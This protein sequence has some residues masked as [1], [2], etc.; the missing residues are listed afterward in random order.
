MQNYPSLKEQID[1]ALQTIRSRT[2]SEPTIGVILGTGLSSLTDNI[3]INLEIPYEEIPNFP[4]STVESHAG[5]LIFG[6]IAG[7]DIVAMQGRFHFYEGYSM[8]QITFP[9]RVMKWLG[10]HSLLMSN[11]GGSLN[12]NFRKTDLM[13]IEDHINLTGDNP[14]TGEHDDSF[15]PRFVDMSEP[16]SKRL[17][18]LSEDIALEN[19][20]KIQKG[21]YAIINGPSLETRA[22]YRFLRFAGADV[23][24]M[25]TIPEC[26]V[27]RQMG[28]EV[29]AVS[30]ITDECYPDALKPVTLQEMIASANV[31]IPKLTKLFSEVIRKI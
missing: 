8:R 5:K 13:L 9:V 20:F 1:L 29:L 2:Q 4:L 31:A 22:E 19:K 25:S 10:V 30:I 11:A 18:E 7:K 3:E 24:G 17:I 14:L 6:K 15:G 28:M 16:Y 26:I 21:V 23:I 27:A 12:P